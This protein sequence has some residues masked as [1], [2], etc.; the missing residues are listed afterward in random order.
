VKEDIL[1]IYKKSG[2]LR[3]G[4]FQLTSG[5]HTDSYLQSALVLQYPEYASRIGEEIAARFRNERVE[6]VVGPAVGGIILSHVVGKALGARSIYVERKGGKLIFYRGFE[7]KPKERTLIVEDVVTT[8]G[9]VQETIEVVEKY[10]TEVV[11]IGSIVERSGGKV[12]FS[13]PYRPLLVIE[14]RSYPPSNC[15]L[16]KKGESVTIPGSRGL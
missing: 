6:V 16:C 13:V 7:I 8:G 14:A 10:G 2:G 3:T 4:H 15:P 1:E 9:S 11:G 5:L 12:R